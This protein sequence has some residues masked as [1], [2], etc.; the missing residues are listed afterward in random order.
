MRTEALE[1]VKL[2]FELLDADGNGFIEAD[3]FAL[4]A[5]RVNQ[6]ASDST[7]AARQS[8]AAAFQRYWTALSTGLDADGDGRISFEEYTA[9]VLSPE[10][11]DGAIAEFADALGALGDPHGEGLVERPRFLDLMTAIGFAVPRI[12]ALF[13]AYRPDERDRVHA[14]TWVESIKEYYAPDK[15]GTAADLLVGPVA[16]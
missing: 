9:C 2:V 14:A 15:A 3:D 8:M 10:R 7:D 5:G 16:V 6:V 13:D 4:M 1:R 12:N 11:F